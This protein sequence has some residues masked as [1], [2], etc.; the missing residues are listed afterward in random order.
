[1]NTSRKLTM[2]QALVLFLDN[3]YIEI[4]GEE[5][6]FVHG[7]MGIFGHGNAVGL[8]QALHQYKDKIR[9]VQGKNEQDI[10]H[11]CMAYAK[12]NRRR[13]IYAC[14]ASVGPGSLNL[15][16]A[17]GNATVNKIPLLLL[18]ADTFA[19]RQP[20]PVLQQVENEMDY[21]VT[22]NNAFKP[23]SR[24][25]DRISRPEQL[26]TACLH[27]MRV[28]TDPELTGA[29]TLCLPQD[30]QAEAYD[31]PEE[32]LSK[33]VWHF[34]RQPA[35]AKSIERA[36]D[37]I[38][39]SK[40]PFIISGGGVRYSDAG[41]QVAE[42]SEM[43]KLPVAETQA[44]KGEIASAHPNYTGCVGICGT[45]AANELMKESDLVI[46]IG[47]KLNDFV[48]NSKGGVKRPDIPV[49]SI[50]VSRMDALK[51]DS[52]SVVADAREGVS[53]LYKALAARQYKTGY[54]DE[55][56][57]AQ[58]RW[59]VELDRLSQLNPREGLS[60]TRVLMELN[61]LLGQDDVIIAAS[62]SLPSDL[63]RIWTV[64]APGTYHLEY[65]FSCMGYET[66][67][68][69]GVKMAEPDKE[70]YVFVGD[71]GFLMSHSNL[72][73]SLQEK[74]KMNILLFNNNGHQC[75]HN[76]QRSQGVDTFGTEFRYREEAT[77]D[78]SGSYL[79]IDFVKVAEGYGAKSCR[80]RTVDELKAAIAWSRQEK[81]STLIEISVLPG[82]M[83][84]GYANFWRVG[85][86]SVA[87]SEAVQE[88]ARHLDTIVKTIRKY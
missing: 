6:K 11:A 74:Q 75:I 66:A 25:W 2:S 5:S 62:G 68:A 35:P 12:Q 38:A 10:A 73:T 44:G 1:M 61:S 24:Y 71:G 42:L 60:Q 36:A 50:N 22:A 83:T 16:T 8:G 67:G 64:K 29:V 28:L 43:F 48:T 13:A 55:I 81:Q 59:Q 30:V 21:T 69:L 37:L 33:R 23:V 63:E 70:V 9:F 31:Y 27:A 45:L 56:T 72:V 15:V 82:T 65:G 18:P 88:A 41:R 80:V 14:T 17:A 76:L 32:F 19:D 78:L 34:D 52:C 58:S 85:T 46:A 26:M 53:A 39:A 77:G 20:D 40:R 49:V 7:V 54:G 57:Q 86:A 3:Q 84:E 47:T 87:K 4:D 51:M 79:P